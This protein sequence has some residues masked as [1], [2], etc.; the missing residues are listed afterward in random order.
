M[1]ISLS[2]TCLLFIIET[3]QINPVYIYVKRTLFPSQKGYKLAYSCY[4]LIPVPGV[5]ILYLSTTKK[6]KK[7]K[8]I[9]KKKKKE[10]EALL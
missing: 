2:L 9:K 8:K 7:G 3:T 1:S 10:R 5:M 6:K 4:V